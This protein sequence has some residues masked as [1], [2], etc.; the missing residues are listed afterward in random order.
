MVPEQRHGGKK[1][2][3]M[4]SL[5]KPQSLTPVTNPNQAIPFNS[6]QTVLPS[7][8]QVFKHEPVGAILIEILTAGMEEG[9]FY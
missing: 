6:S 4:L 7:G 1:S 2:R 8:N 3:E 5:L 9:S